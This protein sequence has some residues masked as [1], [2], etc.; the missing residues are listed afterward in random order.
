MSIV[1]LS[2]VLPA[3]RLMHVTQATVVAGA[4][5]GAEEV[6]FDEPSIL[7]LLSP[8]ASIQN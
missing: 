3:W 8:A 5:F 7:P 1:G 2:L 6:T 4:M